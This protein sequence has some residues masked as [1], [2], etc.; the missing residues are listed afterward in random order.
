M[1]PLPFESTPPALAYQTW[2]VAPKYSQDQRYVPDDV[3][4]PQTSRHCPL[5][6]AQA[7]VTFHAPPNRSHLFSRRHRSWPALMSPGHAPSSF[8]NAAP[9]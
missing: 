7:F 8:S 9:W 1:C 4:P 3:P 5:P 2:E 6:F